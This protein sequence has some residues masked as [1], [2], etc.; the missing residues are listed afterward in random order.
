VRYSRDY[1]KVSQRRRQFTGYFKEKG[2]EYPAIICY[3]VKE[4]A[5]VRR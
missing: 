3:A 4:G 2:F 5:N 1:E